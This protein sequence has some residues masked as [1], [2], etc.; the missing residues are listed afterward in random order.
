VR[1][2]RPF[3]AADNFWA[4]GAFPFE[5]HVCFADGLRLR[6]YL[7]TAQETLDL[8]WRQSIQGSYLPQ[9]S[10]GRRAEVVPCGQWRARRDGIPAIYGIAGNVESATC[11]I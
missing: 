10:D 11:R 5:Q 6:I 8:D 2:S 4:F 3:G 9:D 1:E 7:L